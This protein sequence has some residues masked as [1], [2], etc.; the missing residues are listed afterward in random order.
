MH[1]EKISFSLKRVFLTTYIFFIQSGEHYAN[2]SGCYVRG[3]RW[4]DRLTNKYVVFVRI[5]QSKGGESNKISVFVRE[6][7]GKGENVGRE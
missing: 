2:K 5:R 1:Q 3:W 6:G 7:D 4:I